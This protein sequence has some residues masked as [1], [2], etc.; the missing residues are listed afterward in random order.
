[1]SSLREKNSFRLPPDLVRQLDGMARTRNVPRTAIVEA[2]LASFLSAD[3]PDRLEA[4]V[5]RRLDRITRQL[6][7]LEWHVELTSETLALF[8][9]FWLNT[10]APLPESA[11]KAAQAMG[12]ER[13]VR[14]VE[15]LAKRMDSGP[16]LK[17]EVASDVVGSPKA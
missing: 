9:R 14:F 11:T 10:H 15:S 12:K 8:I 7:R 4:A 6:D 5:S 17:N 2:A 16:R 1:M 3:G 13:W